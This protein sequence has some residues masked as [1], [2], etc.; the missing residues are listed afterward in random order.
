MAK[1][2][3]KTKEMFKPYNAAA[4]PDSMPFPALALVATTKGEETAVPRLNEH[5]RSWILDVAL[6][7]VDLAGLATKKSATAFY[8]QVKNDAFD[9]KAFQHTPQDGDVAEEACLPTLVAAWKRENKKKNSKSKKSGGDDGDASDDEEEQQDEGG[10]VGLVRGYTKAGWRL[11][12]QKVISN[13]R[14]AEKKRR[15]TNTVGDG[16]SITMAPASALSKLFGIS[17]YTGRDKFRED[18]HDQIQVYSETL[19]DSINAGGKFRKAEALLWAKEDHASWETAAND[20]EDVN[21]KERQA[22]VA[23]GF[24]HMVDTVHA[25]GKFRPFVAIM[26]MAWLAE[27]GKPQLDWVEAVPEGIHV[28]QPFEKQYTKVA[29]DCINAMY[30]WAEKPLQ[31]YGG[32]PAASARPAPPVFAFTM[33]ALNDMSPNM[34]AHTKSKITNYEDTSEAVFGSE[35]IPWAAIAS[36]PGDYYDTTKFTI[37]FGSNGLG[38]VKS[39]EWHPLAMA[40]ASSAGEGT[41]GFFRKADTSSSVPGEEDEEARRKREAEEQVHHEREVEDDEARRKR[42]EEAQGE[43]ARRERTAEEAARR[44]REAEEVARREREA[45]EVARREREAE[46]EARRKREEEEQGRREREAQNEEARRKREEE[47]HREREAEE[48]ARR[49]REAEEEARRKCEEEEQGRREREEEEK[50]AA[51]K[52][53]RGPKRKADEQLTPNDVG[54]TRRG[55]REARLEREKKL[56]TTV[57][58]KVKPGYDYAEKSPVKRRSAK[59]Y[60]FN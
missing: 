17:A 44:E 3:T 35:D 42:E 41:S 30:A 27:D 56:A 31:D 51:K 14:M 36:A 54:E 26:T 37:T 11:A 16:E 24:Q 25:T 7:G 1:K 15:P 57:G 18:R 23:G 43:E 12:I 20:E 32:A 4:V 22:L 6:R 59:R 46:E 10:R 49:E 9:A 34:V 47:A 53:R 39:T 45:E 5:Q 40:L 33:E 21:W 52:G 50:P 48:A 38:G 58:Q 19:S 8:D 55:G 2:E 29:S 28:R 13:K 60:T